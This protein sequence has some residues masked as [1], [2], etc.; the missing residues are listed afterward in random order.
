MWLYLFFH[1]LLYPCYVYLL[2]HF[3]LSSD[4]FGHQSLALLHGLSSQSHHLYH[5][6]PSHPDPHTSPDYSHNTRTDSRSDTSRPTDLHSTTNW[7]ADRNNGHRNNTDR[8][9]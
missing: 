2:I 7:Y 5:T 4:M 6:N 9:L 3:Y 8:S 1:F